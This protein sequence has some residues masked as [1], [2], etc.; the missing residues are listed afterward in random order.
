MKRMQLDRIHIETED[1]LG[2]G[3]FNICV[4]TAGWNTDADNVSGRV[5][6]KG[7]ILHLYPFSLVEMSG[8]KIICVA[9]QI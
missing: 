7:C 3:A 6:D 5:F 8:G 2:R 9:T 4:K 1:G